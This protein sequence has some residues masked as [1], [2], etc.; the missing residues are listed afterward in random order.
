MADQEE[1]SY[2]EESYEGES[3]EEEGHSS[4]SFTEVTHQSWGSRLQEQ[5]SKSVIGFVM[6]LAAFPLLFWNEGR[7]VDVAKAL[8]EGKGAVIPVT[9]DA[10]DASNNGQLIHFSG[11]ATTD[12]QLADLDFGVETGALKLRRTTEMYQ[13]DEE[14][15]ER[16]EK[17][18]GG[19]EKTV[20]SYKYR[21][22]WSENHIDSGSFRKRAGHE[23]PAAIPY[24]SD[25][26][27]ADRIVVGAFQLSPSLIEKIDAFE[28]MRLPANAVEQIG[29][30]TVHRTGNSLYVGDS[31]SSPQIGDLKVRF[32][33]IPTETEV[34]VVSRQNGSRLEPYLSKT[35]TVEL[36]QVGL[37]S[38]DLMF[39]AAEEELAMETWLLRI[40]GI[41]MM[42]IGLTM[43]F[44][45]LETVIDRIPFVGIHIGTV[46]GVGT[47]LI[48]ILIALPLALLTIAIAW[49]FARPIVSIV[50]LVLA[51]GGFVGL[52]KFGDK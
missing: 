7:A 26:Y 31:P 21:K 52:R 45:I 27:V 5:A 11:E 16:K 13:W 12:E 37:A 10:V 4:D 36:L 40:V 19:G 43:L 24:E 2:E 18:S 33:I 51:I 28:E 3:Y 20:T 50:L 25:E 1:E 17:T 15:E 47:T 8:E 9:S 29:G 35:G 39:N 34:S 41:A 46:V 6:F 22:T 42:A 30:R 44:K 23:N 14:K 48:A 38:A 49:F 32:E